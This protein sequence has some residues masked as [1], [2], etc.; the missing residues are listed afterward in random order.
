MTKIAP[1]L[2]L[3]E[4]AEEAA[5]V[6]LSAFGGRTLAVAHYAE[7]MPGPA[8]QVMIVELELAG[9]RF[10]L[11]NGGPRFTIN[12]SISCFAHTDTA[13]DAR[14]VHDVLIE[15]GHALMPLGAYPWSACYAWVQ[16]RFGASWQIITARRPP[17]GATLVPC[18]M[19]SGPRRGRAEEAMRA[20]C[21]VLPGSRVESLERYAPAEGPAGMVKH[22]RFTLAGQD[23]VA[24]DS[25]AAHDIAFDEGVSLS[26]SCADQSELDRLWDGLGEGGAQGRCGWLEDRFGVS[27]QVVPGHLVELLAR[28]DAAAS[29]RMFQAMLP[30]GRLD[31][32]ALER[33]FFGGEP[34]R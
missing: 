31:V 23:F 34:R 10:Q 30:M 19:F 33:A 20:W 1:C 7:G 24:M 27:W 13:E 5:R 17:S 15:G 14:R 6:Y 16:D 29:A 8:G 28:G 18:F 32:A 2:W 12:P 3:D 21:D 26:V 4:Q 9:Q 11:L 22:G 25:H